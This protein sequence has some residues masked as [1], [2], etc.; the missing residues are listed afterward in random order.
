MRVAMSFCLCALLSQS[1]AAQVDL[2][3]HWPLQ[4]DAVDDSKSQMP[5]RGKDI[6]FVDD[7]PSALLNR[8]AVFDGVSSVVNVDHSDRLTIGDGPFSFGAWVKPSEATDDVLGDI[9]S[10]YDPDGRTGFVLGL[11]SHLGVTSAQSNSRQLHFGIDHGQIEPAFTDHG[12]LGTAVY[13]F[14][15][16]VHKDKLYASTCHAGRDETGR[17]YRFEGGSE[18]TDL[19]SPDRCNAFSAMCVHKGEL[20]VASSKYRLAGSSLVES[21]NP[22]F[23]GRVFRLDLD[24]KW[25]D[26]GRVSSDTEAISSMI[27]F[28]GKLY[29]CSLYKPAGFFRFDGGETWTQCPLPEGKRVEATT[30]F[31]GGLFATCYDEGSVFRFDGDKWITVGSIPNATQTYGFAVH[32][33]NL[34]VSEW[35]QAH[36]FRYKSGTEWEDTGKLGSELEAMP[37][38]V[39]NGK[40]YCG[41]LPLAEIYRYDGDNNWA[42]IGRVDMTPDVRY[43]RA[44]AMA[45]FQ[46]R[47]FVGALPSGRVLS[48][49]AGRNATWDRQ[50]PSGWHH[51]AAV[52]DADRLRLYVDGEQVAES[53]AFESHTYGWS[54]TGS[55][56]IGFGAQD[57]FQGNL[58][59]VRMYRGALSINEIRELAKR[60]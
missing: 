38:L 59:D 29:A 26:C 14:S 20:Y 48:I 10:N 32:Q 7:G 5:S 15:L 12:R 30:V 25:V 39:Y 9:A 19:G 47:L 42:K 34:F 3:G 50:F 35:P 13:I 2:V 43:R 33:G 22:N 27:E 54:E 11:Y 4:N 57:Y 36:V 56:K 51:V 8:S 6:Q 21:E 24:D 60:E 31:N 16:C 52:R 17:V 53:K 58:S 28:K 41:T 37:L 44:W 18:W 40:M 1:V 46:G 45:V 49:E 23:G 55:L